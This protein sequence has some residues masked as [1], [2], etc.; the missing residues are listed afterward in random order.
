ML[1][2]GFVHCCEVSW[3]SCIPP[4][5]YQQIQYMFLSH[6]YKYHSLYYIDENFA[7]IPH[8]QAQCGQIVNL[9]HK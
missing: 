7:I 5:Q 8:F 9:C 3:M 2:R 6:L 4:L 1:T